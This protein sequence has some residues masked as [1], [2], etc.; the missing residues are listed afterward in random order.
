LGLIVFH[1]GFLMADITQLLK[2][3]EEGD[4]LASE[5]LLP[6]VYDELR[7]MARHRMNREKPGQTLQPTALVHEAWLRLVDEP[8]RT[9]KGRRHFFGAAAEAM[10]R[11]LIERARRQKTAKRGAEAQHVSLEDISVADEAPPDTFLAIDEAIVR[12]EA[13]NPEAAQIVKLRFFIGLKGEE[14]ASAMGVS[15]RTAR[16]LWIFAKAWLFA[17]LGRDQESD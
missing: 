6:L 2:S 5:E 9:W 11:I 14:S 15:E 17:E 16:R 10:R 1:Q 12:L 13:I 8:G 4:P 3:V 7:R